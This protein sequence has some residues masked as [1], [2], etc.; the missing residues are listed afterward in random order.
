MKPG[1]INKLTILTAVFVVLTMGSCKKFL[2]QQ[3]ITEVDTKGVFKDVN[4]TLAA[5]AGVYNRLTGDN[6]YGLKLALHYP[7]DEDILMGPSGNND[8][9]RAMAHYSLT[10]LNSELPPVFNQLFEGISL[11]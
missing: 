2:D 7:V 8:D 5:L 11:A 10:A 1:R 9:R 4:T 6:A 3:P